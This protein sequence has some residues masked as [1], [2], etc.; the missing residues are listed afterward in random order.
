MQMEFDLLQV[1]MRAFDTITFL[2]LKALIQVQVQVQ[3][4]KPVFLFY[5]SVDKLFLSADY[6]SYEICCVRLLQE[7]FFLLSC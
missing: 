5:V 3:L 7:H 6:A 4:L 1:F 2:Y